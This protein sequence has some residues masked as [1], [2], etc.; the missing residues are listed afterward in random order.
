MGWWKVEGTNNM[1]GD[2]PLDLL[3]EAV[4]G[5]VSGYEAAFKRRP[6]KTEW[7]ALLVAVLGGE[8]PDQRVLDRGI[9]KSVGIETG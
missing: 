1:I 8:E 2:T 6:T 7:E 3:G 9:V 5:V 4:M